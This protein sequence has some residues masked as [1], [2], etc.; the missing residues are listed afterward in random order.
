L[1][2]LAEAALKITADSGDGKGFRTREEMIKRFFF[3]GVDVPGNEFSI[4]VSIEDPS[5]ILPD[6][7]DA[8]FS[9]GDEAM[10]AA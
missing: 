6:V 3:N 2:V 1:P 10:V 4:G 5:S 8:K 9:V 7:T